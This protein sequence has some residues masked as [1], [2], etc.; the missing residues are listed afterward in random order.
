MKYKSEITSLKQK[1]ISDYET[2]PKIDHIHNLSKISYYDTHG[3]PI[4]YF[5]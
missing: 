2:V 4:W 3:N 5:Y 1:M